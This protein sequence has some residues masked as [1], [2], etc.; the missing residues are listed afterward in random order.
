MVAQPQWSEP[1]GPTG[2]ELQGGRLD[3]NPVHI[4]R[5]GPLGHVDG[6]DTHQSRVLML[7]IIRRWFPLRA[8]QPDENN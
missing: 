8:K 5:G 4:R 2:R 7:L 1:R 3:W 6:L